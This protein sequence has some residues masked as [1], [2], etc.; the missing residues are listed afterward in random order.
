MRVIEKHSQRC[1]IEYLEYASSPGSRIKGLIGR[2]SLPGGYG[3]FL[4]RCSSIHTCFMS[5][6]IDIIYLDGSWKVL[7]TVECMKPWRLSWRPG[8]SGVVETAAGWIEKH[9]IGPGTELT[10]I[11]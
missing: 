5:L 8:A 11:S 9:G 7:K 2:R 4:P 1:V 6:T 3:L 10:R